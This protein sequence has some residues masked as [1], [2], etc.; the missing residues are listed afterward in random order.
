MVDEIVIEGYGLEQHRVSTGI[1][2]LDWL[3][4]DAQEVGGLPL[5]ALYELYGPPGSGKSTLAL[6]LAGRVEAQGKIVLVD[7]EVSAETG[8]MRS[9]LQQ[10]GFRGRLHVIR[11]V[12]EDGKVIPVE[13]VCQSAIDSLVMEGTSAVVIDS[14]G[15]FTTLSEV[16]GDLT[17]A[18]MGRRGSAVARLTRRILYRLLE[19]EG[20]VIAVNH[21]HVVLGGM[22]YWTPGGR[23]KEFGANARM[24][25]FMVEKNLPYGGIVSK[26]LLSKLRY[27]GL[28]DEHTH[29]VVVPGYGVIPEL[30]VMFDAIDMK[31]AQRTSHGVS[32]GGKTVGRLSTIFEKVLSGERDIC[33]PFYE[34]MSWSEYLKRT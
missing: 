10:A 18:N 3:L 16:Q 32:V 28:R 8:H 26:L 14:L 21:E 12:R 23:T 24:R 34:E 29:I 22:G 7:L 15:M 6:Y 31:K 20:I 17:D 4:R 5:R 19:R 30:C 33:V 1:P 2:G 9:T 27:G 13:D 25:L 11:P